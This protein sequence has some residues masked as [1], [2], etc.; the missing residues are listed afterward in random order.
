MKYYEQLLE[1]FNKL[2]KRTFKL[3]VLEQE[4]PTNAIIALFSNAQ[5]GDFQ[6]LPPPLDSFKVRISDDNSINVMDLSMQRQAKVT[7]PQRQRVEETG[8]ATEIWQNMIA[9][10]TGQKQGTQTGPGQTPPG[11]TVVTP[12]TMP[13]P[14]G[15]AAMESGFT[16]PELIGPGNLFEE[17][18][19]KASKLCDKL[20]EMGIDK[21]CNH[22][23][24]YFGGAASQSPEKAFAPNR[25]K[26]SYDE[27][28]KILT[29]SKLEE[30]ESKEAIKSID[31]L[32]DQLN[33][34]N[35]IDGVELNKRFAVAGDGSVLITIGPESSEGYILKDKPGVYKALLYAA[36]EK[37][38]PT[39]VPDAMW[40]TGKVPLKP[41]G[42]PM[43]TADPSLFELPTFTPRVSSG[44]AKGIRGKMLEEVYMLR[45]LAK[46][47]AESRNALNMKGEELNTPACV[48]FKSASERFQ[49]HK[50]NWPTIHEWAAEHD[51]G[52]AIKKDDAGLYEVVKASGIQG[53]NLVKIVGAMFALSEKIDDAIGVTMS[54]PVGLSPGE[55]EKPD[56]TYVWNTEE[57]AKA[58][59]ENLGFTEDDI[60]TGMIKQGTIGEAF[61]GSAIPDLEQYYRDNHDP[62][63]TDFVFYHGTGL[64]HFEGGGVHSMHA[65]VRQHGSLTKTMADPE[66]QMRKRAAEYFNH[67]TLEAKAVN[68]YHADK[69]NGILGNVKAGVTLQ[70][71]PDPT[72]PKKKVTRDPLLDLISSH[73]D[74][75][76]TDSD[77][78]EL[79]NDGL[80]HFM[81]KYVSNGAWTNKKQT[82]EEREHIA[83]GVSRQ[84]MWRRMNTDLHSKDT[85]TKKTALNYLATSTFITGGAHD[86]TTSTSVRNLESFRHISIIHNEGMNFVRNAV[87][88]VGGIEIIYPTGKDAD[89]YGEGN[90]LK[91]RDN[92][93]PDSYVTLRLTKDKGEPKWS[94]EYSSG[95]L[96]AHDRLKSTQP[97]LQAA[98]TSYGDIENMI[99]E[100]LDNQ[101]DMLLKILSS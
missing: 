60:A 46:H 72:N 33:S 91:F 8:T 96:M 3:T 34:G 85:A 49:K 32:L 74:A 64:K 24:N 81:E 21:S 62:D 73:L 45:I 50:A 87:N 35:L 17:M 65:G 83:E 89:E 9:A 75:T 78:H 27:E 13:T 58:G 59:L 101:K 53:E 67:S 92:S 6:P 18:R 61:K 5:K 55:G 10:F 7:N 14:P 77:Y 23:L 36:M 15:Q 1:S 19:N 82:L 57:E 80:K 40:G 28:Y 93:N 43:E 16:D 56:V 47:C 44:A 38:D 88:G 20:L 30:Q 39:S 52:A 99:Q 76:Q 31:W 54:V 22:F 41:N 71:V 29:K 12:R 11:Q 4:D 37:V 98:S 70:D 66:S 2:K 68:A 97:S 69:V 48:M 26:W 86:D 94:V 25:T 79:R 84:L 42:Q 95:F 63:G 90:S 100:Y 51:L